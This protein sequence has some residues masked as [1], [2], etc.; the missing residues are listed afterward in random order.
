M[1]VF[2]FPQFE[3]GHFWIYLSRLNDYRAHLNQNVQKREVCEII[4]VSLNSTSWDYVEFI[5]P[6][7]VLGL[8]SKTQDEVWDFFEKLA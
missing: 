4:A 2:N 6:R 3:H 5:C 8:L 1:P 7:G